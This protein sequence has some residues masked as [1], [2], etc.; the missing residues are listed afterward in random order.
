MSYKDPKYQQKYRADNQEKMKE[1]QSKLREDLNQHAINSITSGEI[2]DQKKWDLWCNQIKKGAAKYPYSVDFTNDII[3]EMMTKGCFYCEDISTT[4]DRV[5]SKL[6]HTPNNCVGCCRCCNFSKGAA[7]PDTFI[8]KAYYRAREEYVDDIVDIWFVNKQKPSMSSYKT[9]AQKQG[10]PFELTKKDWE[11]LING[12]CEYCKRTP[13]T[14]FGIDK[15]D[16]IKGYVLENVV[17]CCYDC[18]IDK[19]IIDIVNTMKRNERIA[20]R[21]DAGKLV[22]G[23]FEKSIIHNGRHLSSKKVYAYGNVYSSKIEASRALG[24]YHCYV[25]RCIKNGWYVDDIFEITEN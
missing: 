16:P 13:A 2:N 3:F 20:S 22:I 7:Y 18:N 25:G 17:T 19:Y 14:W 15:V 21:V 9:R 23:E 5:D 8:R 4:I 24:K 10:V 12:D 11:L 6:E 1:Y